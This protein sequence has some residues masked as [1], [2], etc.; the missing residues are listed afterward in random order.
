MTEKEITKETNEA[1]KVPKTRK[2]KT[3]YKREYA[4]KNTSKIVN[5][6]E[7]KYRSKKSTKKKKY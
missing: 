4:K 5:K 1:N 7:K 3:P 6:D 2:R